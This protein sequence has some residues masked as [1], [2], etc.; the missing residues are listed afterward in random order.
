[1]ANEFG[2]INNASKIAVANLADGTDGQLITWDSDGHAAVVTTGLA[3]YILYSR[4]VGVP[5]DF[6]SFLSSLDTTLNATVAYNPVDIDKFIVLDTSDDGTMRH[7]LFSVLKSTLKTYFDG[8][9]SALA[10]L[11]TQVFSVAAA[12]AIAHAVRADQIQTQSL[13]A[14]TTGGTDTAFTL[15]TL[16]TPVALTTN[17][18]W[19]VI[20]NATAGA[21]PTLNRDSKGAK[22]LKYY[23]SVGAKS[24]CG[25]AT[26][27]ANMRADVVYDGTDY[28]V[29]DT[30]PPVPGAAVLAD[31]DYGDISV[32]GTG[33]VLSVDANAI[34]LAKLATQAAET[35][36]ANA[37]AGAAVPT[38]LALAEQTVLG[39]ITGG[40]VVGLTAAQIRT[41]ANVADGSQVNV[42]EGVTGTAPIV[43]G[44]IAAKS[45]A[46]SIAAATTA[47]AGSMSAADKLRLNSMEHNYLI[48]GGFDFWQRIVPTTA[49]AMSDDVYNAPD[50]WY[51]LVQ[52]VNATINRNAG[53]GTSQYSCKLVAGGTTNRYGIAQIVEGRDS[54]PLRGQTVIAQCRVK[55]VNNA[56]SGTR[57]Y[58]IALL[59]WTGTVDAVTS[60]LVKA[61]QWANGTFTVNNFF[62][63]TTFTVV[64]CATVTATHNTETMLSVSGAVSAS[65]NNLIVFIWTEDVPTHASDYVLIG[66]AGLFV[67]NAELLWSPNNDINDERARCDRYCIALGGEVVY[68]VIGNGFCYG[69]TTAAVAYF[70]PVQFRAVPIIG[71]TTVAN[72]SVLN[73]AGN[74][75]ACTGLTVNATICSSRILYMAAVVASGLVA[76]AGTMLIKSNNTTDKLI[77]SCEL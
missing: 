72:F 13:Q 61:G 51:S 76:G 67:G 53:I 3:G 54:I 46:I 71:F 10:G 62:A 18:R 63:N 55:P 7:V 23:N 30:I 69:T 52:A 60:Q 44:A 75:V 14:Y 4:G 58:R 21:T 9:Y 2:T 11:A 73:T 35:V 68:E 56:G 48:N 29:L 39:R 20:F 43:A 57:K 50:R 64:G 28:V 59:E 49:T 36:L 17:E 42:L 16:G 74:L 66:E 6:N 33:T 26:I 22:A 25:A 47:A 27:I 24:S 12:T 65:C 19:H 31:G 70:P 32:S 77:I 5:P 41:L 34:T 38:A 1:M 15:T 45:Q 37:T 40:H 8:I